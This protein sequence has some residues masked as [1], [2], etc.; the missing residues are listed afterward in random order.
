[1]KLNFEDLN[2]SLIKWKK[3]FLLQKRADECSK[4]TIEV[5]SRVL[6][7]FIE[8]SL[9]YNEDYTME[10]INSMYLT[11]YKTYL[12]EL[13]LGI[14]TRNTHLTVIKIF[15]GFITSSNEEQHDYTKVISSTKKI[16]SEN[17][18]DGLKETQY[19]NKTERERLIAYLEKLFSKKPNNFFAV[20][21]YLL[22]KIL[23]Y[24]APRASELINLKLSEISIDEE[25]N[26]YYVLL[27]HG[28]GNK[29]YKDWIMKDKIEY[30]LEDYIK[31]VG[32]LECSIAAR[33]NK[34]TMTRQELYKSINSLLKAAGIKKQGV[35]LFRHSLGKRLT[36]EENL[37][38]VQVQK[39]LNHANITTTAKFYA[40]VNE[41]DKK[42]IA[43][44]L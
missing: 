38:L 42:Q 20:R 44:V 17:I 7:H 21:N 5:Y 30:A 31:I 41:Q 4:N 8:F 3:E 26:R 36:V 23:I 11:A 33:R 14:S 24:C 10:M 27:F 25:N 40:N 34:T 19:L 13:N 29:L 22:L 35:H 43:D 6:D 12:Q 18:T 15:L 2:T 39:K 16:K 37:N 28:K 9:E 1:M 32:N